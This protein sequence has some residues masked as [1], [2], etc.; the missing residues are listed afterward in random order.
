MYLNKTV[1]LTYYYTTILH[2]PPLIIDN[3]N[4]STTVCG[5]RQRQQK[6]PMN[7]LE[8]YATFGSVFHSIYEIDR[9]GK[10]AAASDC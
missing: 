2:H 4:L 3:M 9:G 6:S 7:R 1:Y 10:V 5:E 8:V